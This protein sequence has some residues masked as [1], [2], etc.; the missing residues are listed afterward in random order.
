M[1]LW[2]AASSAPPSAQ[3]L[4]DN[5]IHRRHELGVDVHD[6]EGTESVLTGPVAEPGLHTSEGGK[7]PL[8]CGCC[9]R[10]GGSYDQHLP[11]GGENFWRTESAPP[12][13]LQRH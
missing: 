8:F 1:L 13:R 2:E 10:L 5:F 4:H 6:S 9:H 11:G 12:G 3:K 7:R